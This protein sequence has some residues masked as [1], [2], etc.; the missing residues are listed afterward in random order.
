MFNILKKEKKQNDDGIVILKKTEPNVC[1]GTDATLNTNAPKEI[2]SDNMI[3]FNVTSSFRSVMMIPDP[4]IDNSE[5]LNYISAFAVP[6]ENGTFLFLEKN[7]DYRMNN[8]RQSS[9]ALVKENIFPD[10]VSLVKDC[11]LAESNGFHSITHGLPEN[12]G[13]SVNIKYSDGEYISFSDNQ[14]PVISV[15][16]GIKIAKLFAEAMK[17]SIID[18]PD[19][20]A[21]RKIR[22]DEERGS[23]GFTRAI[24]TFNSDGTGTNFK[25]QRFDDPKVYESEKP[26]DADTITAIKNN[27]EA[28]GILAWSGIPESYYKNNRN[29]TLTFVFE[30]NQEI[31]VRGDRLLPD[32]I[33]GGFFNIELE[34]TTKH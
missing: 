3:L 29:K 9:W 25:S 14:S 1:G 33:Q 17:G 10:L 20:S 27:I 11:G 19:V 22:F 7:S 23:D 26:V 28:N 34:M 5:S 16:T 15:S 30:D 31:T 18:L 2:K 21:I 4:D 12:F 8:N 24:L 32:R 6:S 13:G